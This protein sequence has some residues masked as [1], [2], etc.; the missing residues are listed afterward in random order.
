MSTFPEIFNESETISEFY[1]HTC[2]CNYQSRYNLSRDVSRVTCPRDL[3]TVRRLAANWRVPGVAG[4]CV[5]E[6]AGPLRPGQPRLGHGL[7]AWI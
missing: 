3:V 1:W 2:A 7:G 5:G 4:W 6:A